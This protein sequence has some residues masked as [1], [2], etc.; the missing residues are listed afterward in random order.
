M[1]PRLKIGDFGDYGTHKTNGIIT[2]PPPQKKKD[3]FSD[4]E[5]QTRNLSLNETIHLN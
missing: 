5:D 2:S 3:V 4:H 1:C